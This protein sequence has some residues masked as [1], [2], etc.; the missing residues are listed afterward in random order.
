MSTDISGAY[1][2][3]WG[4]ERRNSRRIYVAL[5]HD[6]LIR[7][8]GIISEIISESYTFSVNKMHLKIASENGGHFIPASMC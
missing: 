5:G 2:G 7:P 4:D 8:L 6:E 3:R 1:M